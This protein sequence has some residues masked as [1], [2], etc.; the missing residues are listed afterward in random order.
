M[1]RQVQEFD[2]RMVLGFEELKNEII[3]VTDEQGVLREKITKNHEHLDSLVRL[4]Y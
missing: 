2:D 1:Q 4:D 3:R